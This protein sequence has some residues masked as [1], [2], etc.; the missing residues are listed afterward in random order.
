MSPELQTVLEDLTALEGEIE[1]KL[2]AGDERDAV[3]LIREYFR[4]VAGVF[5]DVDR[6]PKDFCMR[7]SA[8]SQSLKAVLALC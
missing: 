8:V 7:L 6:S 4:V 1:A 3:D 5:R 2:P